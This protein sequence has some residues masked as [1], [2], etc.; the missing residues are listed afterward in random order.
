MS[1]VKQF[2]PKGY[3]PSTGIYCSS[4]VFTGNWENEL[5]ALEYTP[6]TQLNQDENIRKFDEEKGIHSGYL[7]NSFKSATGES[8]F[9]DTLGDDFWKED[10][11]ADFDYT[12][13]Y[14]S[15]LKNTWVNNIK[16]KYLVT[17]LNLILM[18][19]KI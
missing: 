12:D 17:K 14:S 2:E 10:V 7:Y 9:H 3:N 6:R 8:S 4:Q 5:A 13:S 18:E 16:K 19:K 1:T 15:N 11:P